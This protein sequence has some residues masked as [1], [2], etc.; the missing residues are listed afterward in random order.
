[1]AL[2]LG[3]RLLVGDAAASA[4]GRI[5]N[6]EI[7]IV[8]STRALHGTM[9]IKIKGALRRT[10]NANSLVAYKLGRT[11]R[12]FGHNGP[13]KKIIPPER[14]TSTALTSGDPIPL[15]IPVPEVEIPVPERTISLP[16]RTIQVPAGTI[17]VPART[18]Q[19]PQIT[20]PLSGDYQ[21]RR[22]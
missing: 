5:D 16:E 20:I 14:V 7:V 1:M 22:S 19:G 17:Q 6:S 21:Q 4:P 2:K 12:H 9:L 11:F 13:Q 18:V 10:T 15:L 3:D 8:D